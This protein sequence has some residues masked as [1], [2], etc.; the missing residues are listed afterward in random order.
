MKPLNLLSSVLPIL[1]V[2][3][4]S[5]PCAVG[6]GFLL[7]V[8]KNCLLV[9]AAH[10]ADEMQN[11]RLYIPSTPGKPLIEL[12]PSAICTK[13]PAG[14]REEDKID[15]AF[16]DLP[17]EIVSL[18]ENDFW[19]V[20]S[21]FLLPGVQGLPPQNLSFVGYPHKATKIKYGTSKLN[22]GAEQFTGVCVADTLYQEV[23]AKPST[24]LAIEFDHKRAMSDA[25]IVTPKDR[26]GMSGGPVYALT[27]G[28]S[29]P[30]VPKIRVVGVAIEHHRSERLLLATKVD[31][32]LQLIAQHFQL[33][34]IAVSDANII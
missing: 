29:L 9:T 5:Q 16:W 19:I 17:P 22:S 30:G 28:G 2:D 8:L 31:L 14:G 10:V 18:V 4:K 12:P 21:L 7:Q 24:H 6:T 11:S 33:A 26:H 15:L 13:T 23:D 1:G 34:E 32:L 20:P 3:A 27:D 25:R